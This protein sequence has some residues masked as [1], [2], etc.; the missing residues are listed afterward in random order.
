[1]LV[2]TSFQICEENM[3]QTRNQTNKFELLLPKAQLS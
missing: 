1:M 2:W 3:C